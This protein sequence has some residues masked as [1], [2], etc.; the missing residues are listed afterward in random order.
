MAISQGP[1]HPLPTRLIVQHHDAGSSLEGE[2]FLGGQLGTMKCAGDRAGE[3]IGLWRIWAKWW[4]L[5]R[6]AM[7]FVVTRV[8]A[9]A[10]SLRDIDAYRALSG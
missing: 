1:I 8:T 7:A 4:A 3:G 5:M 2:S 6:S 9:C 10:R